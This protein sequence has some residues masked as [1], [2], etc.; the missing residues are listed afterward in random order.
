MELAHLARSE[1]LRAADVSDSREAQR[2][3]RLRRLAV[4]LAVV[5]V[6]LVVRA[7]TLVV[8]AADGHPRSH[9]FFGLRL[10]IPAG[11]GPYL[12]SAMLMLVLV[13]VLAVP[14]LGAGRSP[15]VLYR[16]DEI[17][18]D[19]SDVVG[20]G[21]VVEEVIKTLNLFLAHK[22]FR[23]RMGG[24]ARRAVL[25]EGPPGTGKTYLAKAMA[26][27]AGVP[28]LFV[29]SSAFQSMYYGQTN[30]KIRSYFK[31]LR[32]HARREGGAIG[33]IEEI[34]AIG[35]ARSGMGGGGREGVSG[36]VNELLIQLQSFDQPPRSVQLLSGLIDGLNRWL[37]AGRRLRKPR[38]APANILVVG[39]TNRA[40]D[41]DPALLRPGRFDK[42]IT[43]DVPSRAGRR[44][45]IDYY[46]ARKAH[47]PGLDDPSRRET[48]AATTFGYSPVMLEH[49][50]DEALV[51]ALR[52]GAE[53]LSWEDIQR[54][55]LTEELGLAQPVAYAESERRAIA[56]HEA[57]HAT[58]AWLVAAHRKLEVLSIIKRRSAL[59][60]LSHSE[61]E[62]R[63][64]RSQSEIEALIRIA[65]GGMVAEE[66]FFGETSSGVA[67]DLQAATEA[68][69]QMVGSLGMAGRL[70]SLDAV[71]TPGSP[72]LVAKVLADDDGTAAVER[73][74]ATARDDVR[75]LLGDNRHL[76]E[77]LRDAL[78]EREELIGDEIGGV[79]TG[80]DEDHR[81]A[82]VDLT[83]IPA[84]EEARLD[85]PLR[86]R[87]GGS[88]AS[89]S[90]TPRG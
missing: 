34:D 1:V 23:D 81:S 56:T 11:W 7:V 22:T 39:A 32:A 38:V 14:L 35:A 68:A 52:R 78:L 67:G 70:R 71:Q 48:L 24:S 66:L 31:A 80:A 55:K 12:P 65:M 33:F 29:S 27:E 60:L 4:I 16:P 74:L 6:P 88:G 43:V 8:A 46:L 90:A 58:V 63:W 54:A 9:S 47:D 17:D 44:E 69:A 50:L 36:V 62:E 89:D 13:A 37:P 53:R 42:T 59:G 77:A 84:A 61:V 30:R 57:G 49:L 79:L 28:F 73:I 25:F 40:G 26:A 72:N 41:L 5:A 21:P 87:R 51:W 45:I 19:L 20:V 18:T 86:G 64:T 83:A 85:D 75:R 76:V 2:R 3:R 82:V 15:H 10:A